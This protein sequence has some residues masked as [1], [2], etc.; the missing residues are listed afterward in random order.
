[1]KNLKEF[2]EGES[3]IFATHKRIAQKSYVRV[4]SSV[5]WSTIDFHSVT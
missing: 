4:V 2:W 1:M 3:E 5:E